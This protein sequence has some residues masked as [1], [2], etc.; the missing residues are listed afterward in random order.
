MSP[1]PLRHWTTAIVAAV[2]C[3]AIHK[4][5]PYAAAQAGADHAGAAYAC[6]PWLRPRAQH[7][8]LCVKFAEGFIFSGHEI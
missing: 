5:S 6:T 8:A 4:Y 1:G 3:Y 7:K 2:K